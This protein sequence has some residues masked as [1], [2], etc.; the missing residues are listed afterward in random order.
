VEEFWSSKPAVGSSNLSG[1]A[2]QEIIMEIKFKKFEPATSVAKIKI[3]ELIQRGGIIIE[4]RR[5]YVEVKR[6]QSIA[7]IDQYGRVEWRAQ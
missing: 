7:H 3:S 1:P 2:N 4:D 5:D 6:E